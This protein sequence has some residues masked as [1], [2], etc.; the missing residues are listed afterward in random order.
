MLWSR[1][2]DLRLPVMSKSVT[3]ANVSMENLVNK[4][5]G[6]RYREAYPDHGILTVL[7][8]FMMLWQMP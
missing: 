1:K 4:Y 3:F 8:S 7:N 6:F 5:I 2:N